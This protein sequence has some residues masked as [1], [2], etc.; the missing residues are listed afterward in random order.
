VPKDQKQIGAAIS[1][2]RRNRYVRSC[3]SYHECLGLLQKAV[4]FEVCM[5]S[6]CKNGWIN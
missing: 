6:C 3:T 5:Y 4:L 2:E 1:Y